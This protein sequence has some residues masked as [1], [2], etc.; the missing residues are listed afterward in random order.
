M[1]NIIMKVYKNR[2]IHGI[3]GTFITLGVM[4]KKIW[5]HKKGRIGLIL[6]ISIS[7]IAIFAPIIAPYDPYDVLQR[8]E[9]GVG[10][11]L[12][13]L[14]GTTSFGQDIFSMLIYGAR[15]SMSIGIITAILISFTGAIIG[16]AAGYLGKLTDVVIMRIVDVMLVIP[17]LPIVIVLTN[18]FGKSYPMLILIFTLF[19]WAGLSRVV[20]SQVLTIKNTNYVKSTEL[21]GASKW[22]VMIKHILPGVSNQLIMNTAMTAAGVMIAEAGLSF[23]GLGNTEFI[24][25]G[26]MLAEAQTS[27]AFLLG[28]WWWIIAPGIGIFLSVSAFM[29][30]GYSLEEIFNPRMKSS[31]NQYR[32]FKTLNGKYI[33]D[34]F[35][36]MEL[37]DTVGGEFNE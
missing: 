6:L 4:T 33:E 21:F 3:V 35:E 7:L 32:L 2:F 25:W 34:L 29:L 19:G 16:I 12:D 13:H 11:S 36:Q 28:Y 24:S 26:K 20:R 9:R 18:L 8:G 23:L 14:L 22:Y 5:M 37:V 15:V 1:K 17:T 27:G 30:I 10:P 31:T